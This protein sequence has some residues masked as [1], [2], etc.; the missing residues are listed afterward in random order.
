[1]T[2]ALVILTVVEIAA[3]VVV[4]VTYLVLIDRRLRRI[5]A[6]LGKLAFGV[7]AVETH[8]ARIGPSVVQ[9]NQA[10]TELDRA[11]AEVESQATPGR[12]AAQL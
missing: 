11:L 9:L 12:H 7:R 8:T 3:V 2:T 5:S 10:L 6:L 1:M 4:L